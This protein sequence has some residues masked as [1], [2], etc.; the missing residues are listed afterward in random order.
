[1]VAA[2]KRTS[3]EDGGRWEIDVESHFGSWED[4]VHFERP[5][6]ADGTRGGGCVLCTASEA[7]GLDESTVRRVFVKHGERVDG[8]PVIGSKRKLREALQAEKLASGNA[9]ADEMVHSIVVDY[10]VPE[11]VHH[12][13]QGSA[14][15]HQRRS[16][17]RDHL[18]L[19]D[20]RAGGAAMR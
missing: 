16:E 17:P 19:A 5:L 6:L 12:L 1:M 9:Q 7:R 14:H 4:P 20:G 10:C 2:L 3:K 13:G 8:R 15:L 11:H 18:H